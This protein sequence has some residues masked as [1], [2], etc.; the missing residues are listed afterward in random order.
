MSA[1][2]DQRGV[3]APPIRWLDLVQLRSEIAASQPSTQRESIPGHVGT[4]VTVARG[5]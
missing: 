4:A 3:A 1:I 2:L 5:V